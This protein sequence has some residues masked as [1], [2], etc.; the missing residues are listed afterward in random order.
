MPETYE[1]FNLVLEDENILS[2]RKKHLDTHKN[3]IGEISRQ[4]LLLNKARQLFVAEKIDDEDFN[5]LKQTYRESVGDLTD[6]LT[7]ITSILID[8]TNNNEVEWIYNDSN[9]LQSYKYQDIS[10]KR[11]IIDL[12]T[13]ELINVNTGNIGP[14]KIN[15][16]LSKILDC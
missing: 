5:G 8:S 12:L 2:E 14:L 16:A 3:I 7:Q 9:V 10:G 15:K 4:E 11:Y 1:L 6:R 13:P